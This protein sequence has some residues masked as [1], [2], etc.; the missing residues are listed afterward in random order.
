[1]ERFH[2]R[3][4]CSYTYSYTQISFIH[5]RLMLHFNESFAGGFFGIGRTYGAVA[6]FECASASELERD[7]PSALQQAAAWRSRRGER[8]TALHWYFQVAPAAVWAVVHFITGRL[9]VS[10][11]ARPPDLRGLRL[12]VAVFGSPDM[13]QYLDLILYPEAE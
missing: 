8:A 10:P 7:W 3:I 5:T 2:H 4:P 12:E 11:R 9:L 1:M 13:A 6:R